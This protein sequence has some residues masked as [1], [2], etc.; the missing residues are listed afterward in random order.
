MWRV[1]PFRIEFL[2]DDDNIKETFV[3]T[4]PPPKNVYLRISTSDRTEYKERKPSCVYVYV[5]I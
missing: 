1:A 3:A 4:L 5:Y 2:V